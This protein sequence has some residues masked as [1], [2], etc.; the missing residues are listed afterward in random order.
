[1]DWNLAANSNWF[2]FLGCPLPGLLLLFVALKLLG[3][4]G[5][6]TRR[7]FCCDNL[8]CHL[9]STYKVLFLFTGRDF[10][11]WV[12]NAALAENQH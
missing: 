4:S 2:L 3:F 11:F 8:C 5:F 6:I 10:S 12:S 1:M 9:P 7:L